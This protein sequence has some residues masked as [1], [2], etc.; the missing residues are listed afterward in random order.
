MFRSGG[1]LS[2]HDPILFKVD[3]ILGL[4]GEDWNYEIPGEYQEE[5]LLP[6][7]VEREELLKFENQGTQY[8]EV[9]PVTEEEFEPTE[10]LTEE[11]LEPMETVTEEE[12][13]P[14]KPQFEDSV[15]QFLAESA[16][17]N[18]DASPTLGEQLSAT[19][20]ELESRPITPL[21]QFYKVV[22]SSPLPSR[23]SYL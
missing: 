16:Q 6:I 19:A 7:E 15:S 4:G 23:K 3:E 10:T 5:P 20:V 22:P 8:D 13:E 14:T 11:E 9:E 1:R 21:V 2:F 12:S 17:E 18:E